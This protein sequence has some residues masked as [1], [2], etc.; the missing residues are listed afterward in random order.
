ME[1]KVLIWIIIGVVYLIA[2]LRKKQAPP[3]PRRQ[4]QPDPEASTSERPQTFEELL[5]EI[6]GMKQ[7]KPEPEPEPEPFYPAPKPIF[8]KDREPEAARPVE[9]T[10]YDYRDHDKI[11]EVYEEARKQAFLRPSLEESVK[12]S[13]TIVRFDSFKG[14]KFDQ[15]PTQASDILQELRDPKSFRKAFILSEILKRKF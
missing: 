6:E 3:P 9:N 1:L 15:T 10:Y 2:R 5:R 8:E 11:Y 12:L 4:Q 7:P 13:D 14:Y